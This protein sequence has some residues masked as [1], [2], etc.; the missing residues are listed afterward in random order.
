MVQK[1]NIPDPGFKRLPFA[2]LLMPL[3]PGILFRHWY[4][5]VLS[6]PLAIYLLIILIIII[7][8]LFLY[9]NRNNRV[10]KNSQ[11]FLLLSAL[12][13]CGYIICFQNNITENKKW[14]G[15]NLKSVT[16]LSAKVIAPPEKKTKT[17]LVHLAVGKIRRD[18]VWQKATGQL[19]LYIYA[20]DSVPAIAVGDQLILPNKLV[21]ISNRGN[22]FE[23]DYARYL[24]LQGLYFQ[25][26]LPVNELYVI[27][28]KQHASHWL[29]QLR[30]HLFLTIQDNIR[31]TTTM[32][33][34]EATLLNDRSLLDT[35]IW[36][37]YSL[38]GIAH[39]IAI[40][41]MHVSLFFSILLV[42]LWWLKAPG[43]R[44]LKY[45][46]ALPLI[47]LYIALTNFPPS[48]V[49][50]AIMF[51]IVFIGLAFRR[52]VNPLNLLA[53]TGFIIL[54]FKPQWLFDAGIQLSF[55]AVASIFLFFKPLKSYWQP[56]SKI[57][58]A[59]WSLIALSLSVQILVFPIVLYY[60]HQFPIWFLPANIP[61]ALFSF[62][63]MVMALMLFLLNAI[64][65]PCAWLGNIMTVMTHAFHQ[66]IFILSCHTPQSFQHLYISETAF[67]LILLGVV[68]LCLFYF[69]K[70]IL[71]GFLGIGAF[72]LFLAGQIYN[73]TLA[74][75]QNRIVVYNSA[76]HSTIDHF[77]GK[78]CYPAGE[79]DSSI[80]TNL[81]QYVL[82]P[83]RL[84]FHASHIIHEKIPSA[85][86]QIQGKNILVLPA[87]LK[88][89][90]PDTF[91]VDFL[92]VS[93]QCRFQPE[94]WQ[95]AFHPQK[96][97]LDGS[98]PRYK[99]QKWTQRLMVRGLKVQ[100]VQEEGA[101]VFPE[102]FQ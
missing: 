47:W 58:K 59:T 13:L 60:F 5:R 63:L 78:Y 9:K 50:A 24:H 46:L 54:C 97:I 67:W 85:I 2:Y 51:S 87:Q 73:N 94:Q 31:D 96:I 81:D 55:T 37:A 53:A 6:F 34:T 39:I 21:A 43:I 69:Y 19:Q 1:R 72:V 8:F 88:M 48:A 84:G 12:F 74:L 71:F 57:L 66:L 41:G 83:S 40:S 7:G 75:K 3:I 95:A 32:A 4:P 18:N 16:A 64:G 30:S 36:R 98:L 93:N 27:H 77:K 49:R 15:H 22:P 82:L 52:G 17:M 61:A 65:I 14:F 38:T 99:A 10:I 29:K 70:K 92:I 11:S 42:F 26:F 101:W 86:V 33:L 76:K 20:Q 56:K 90:G 23:F 102:A 28:E 25:V 100:N 79:S 91:P 89:N 45:L 68:A 35:Q 44:W 62:L 80:L